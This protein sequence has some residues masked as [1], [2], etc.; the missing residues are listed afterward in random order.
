[1]K[2]QVVLTAVVFAFVQ[3]VPMRAFAT[4]EAVEAG[5]AKPCP[6]NED[7]N[8]RIVQLSLQTATL[9]GQTERLT[10]ATKEFKEQKEKAREMINELQ[11]NEAKIHDD[12]RKRRNMQ[13]TFGVVVAV[14][15][16]ALT[17]I[18]VGVNIANNQPGSR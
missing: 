4:Q 7:L 11:A 9:A 5:V 12:W 3:I 14:I 13:V 17:G 6:T 10:V 18:A 16:G 1:M 15:A 2:C 8:Q